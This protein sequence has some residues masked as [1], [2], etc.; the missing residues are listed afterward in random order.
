MDCNLQAWNEPFPSQ[1]DLSQQQKQTGTVPEKCGVFF[2]ELLACTCFCIRMPCMCVGDHRVQKRASD[3]SE[4]ALQAAV[5]H[6]TWVVSNKPRSSARAK[7]TLNLFT[8][9]PAPWGT[10]LIVT[11]LTRTLSKTMLYFG[12]K[13]TTWSPWF[14]SL[15]SSLWCPGIVQ[16][17]G[18]WVYLDV[19]RSQGTWPWRVCWILLLFAPYTSCLLSSCH[20]WT[21]SSTKQSHQ[22]ALHPH[23]P[24]HHRVQR[25]WNVLKQTF[26]LTRLILSGILI[27]ITKAA[28]ISFLL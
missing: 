17:V 25:L 3:P 4:L 21:I 11:V 14:N 23:Q 15:F 1:V 7:C 18:D 26:S 22:C 19:V 10:V 6:S 28:N 5:N 9:P 20:R 12:S 27:Q 24:S 16:T 13:I 2:K 8:R